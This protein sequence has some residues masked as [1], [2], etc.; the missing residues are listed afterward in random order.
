MMRCLAAMDYFPFF[1]GAA[2]FFAAGFLAAVFLA[3]GLCAAFLAGAALAVFFV[4][5]RLLA[6]GSFAALASART[7]FLRRGASVVGSAATAFTNFL[8]GL[9]ALAFAFSLIAG[10]SVPIADASIS[11]TSDQ[12]MW[13]VDTSEYGSVCTF[14]K[15]R[16]LR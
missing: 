16:A 6:A 3:A 13:Y 11:T 2:A 10:K 4:T 12:R 7:S 8:V 5:L 14:G 9:S 15:L 1:F